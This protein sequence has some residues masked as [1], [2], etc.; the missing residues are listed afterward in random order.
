MIN[1]F[2][3]NNFEKFSVGVSAIDSWNKIQD[4]M[5]VIGYSLSNSLKSTDIFVFCFIEFCSFSVN[6]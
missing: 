3:K 2:R 6:I 4:E 5:G 1:P